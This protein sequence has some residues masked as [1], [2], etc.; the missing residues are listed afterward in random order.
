MQG[1]YYL[2]CMNLLEEE[3]R[4]IG[5]WGQRHLRY[6]RQH[7]RALYTDLLTSGKLNSYL[8]DID[9]QAEELFSQ[10]VKET[11]ER[12]GITEEPKAEQP[13]LWVGRI[14]EIRAR[15]REIVNT[16]LIYS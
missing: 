14:N 5:L 16:E 10:L 7:R 12:E 11:E 1:D 15:A 3:Q 4:P 13:M 2:P 9:E 6:L 8:A